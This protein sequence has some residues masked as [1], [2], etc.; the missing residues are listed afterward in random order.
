[1]SSKALYLAL[2]FGLLLTA[3]SIQRYEVTGFVL[4]VDALNHIVLVSHDRIP[5]YMDAMTMPYRVAKPRVLD[6]LKPG[7]TIGFT[8]VVGKTSSYISNVHVREYTSLERDPVQNRRLALL[9]EAMRR[10]AGSQ[11]VLSAG[12]AVSDFSL[13]DQTDH[14]VTLSQFHGKVVAITF[15]YTRCPLP[16]YCIRLSNNFARLQK[17]FSERMGRDLVL[18]SITFDP[19]HDKPEVLREYAEHLKANPESWHFLTGN[20][21]SVKQVCGMFG[22]NFWPDE[23]L[24]THSLRTAVVDQEGK[25]VANIEGNQFSA[26]QLGD[27]V[28]AT[29]TRSN[30]LKAGVR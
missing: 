6:I 26:I 23:G 25:L 10:S 9:D 5:G 16:D 21:S 12:Q 11:S 17:R 14:P 2:Q 27:L 18:L 19:D 22:V 3:R 7:E 30:N 24:L 20:L 15:I 8:L 4:S 13:V 1:M 29:L 28:E